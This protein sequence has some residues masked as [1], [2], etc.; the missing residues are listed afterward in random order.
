M[1]CDPT[2]GP[3]GSDDDD[4]VWAE[5]VRT[6]ECRCRSGSRVLVCEI[7]VVPTTRLDALESAEA[8]DRP[9]LLCSCRGIVRLLL[10][11]PGGWVCRVSRSALDLGQREAALGNTFVDGAGVIAVF[12]S[13]LELASLRIRHDCIRR[14]VGI[15]S[16]SVDTRSAAVGVFRGWM[17][18]VGVA[19]I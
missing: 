4:K 8:I 14:V 12:V 15:L 6:G 16:A 5:R 19:A 13:I 11:R 9:L 10:D 17:E 3:M 1:Q 18:A 7:W 2:H